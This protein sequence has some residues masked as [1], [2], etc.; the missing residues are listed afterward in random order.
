MIQFINLLFNKI[1]LN[2]ILIH[3]NILIII[4]NKR[5]ALYLFYC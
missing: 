1:Y 4:S 3:K 5:I 2:H